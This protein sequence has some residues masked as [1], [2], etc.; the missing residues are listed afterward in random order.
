MIEILRSTHY[1]PSIKTR[2]ELQP[3]CWI[4]CENPSEEEKQYLL[5]LGIDEDILLDALDP[6]EVPRV[7]LQNHDT[8]FITRLPDI[9]EQVKTVVIDET[10]IN[11]NCQPKLLTAD[12]QEYQLP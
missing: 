5:S 11:D 3:G 9:K 2:T 12:G 4:R 10:V 6:H 8:Y 7:E 1:R